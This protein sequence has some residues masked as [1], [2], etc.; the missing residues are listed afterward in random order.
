MCEKIEKIEDRTPEPIRLNC[1]DAKAARLFVDLV[2]RRGIIAEV[3]DDAPETVVLPW[4]GSPT[5]LLTICSIATAF[6][7]ITEDERKAVKVRGMAD[8]LGMSIDDAEA[9]TQR[10]ADFI[11]QVRERVGSALGDGD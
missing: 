9:L 5:F 8:Q 11:D 10:F 4:G 3:L 7:F 6:G 2:E 1:V